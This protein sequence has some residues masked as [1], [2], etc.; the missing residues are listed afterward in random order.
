MGPMPTLTVVVAIGS[1]GAEIAFAVIAHAVE[2]RL[3]PKPRRG[4]VLCDN[5]AAGEAGELT[6]ALD[7]QH[8]SMAER[9]I[10][11]LGSSMTAR[12]HHE[13]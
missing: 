2:T 13:S 4:A 8:A 3:Q 12:D 11:G 6:E 9:S 5:T 7:V 1:V 10:S